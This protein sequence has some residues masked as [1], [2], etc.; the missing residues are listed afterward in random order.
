MAPP[1]TPLQISFVSRHSPLM[2]RSSCESAISGLCL[3]TK[4]ICNGVFGGATKQRLLACVLMP[5]SKGPGKG[6]RPIAMMEVLVK[7]A[8]HYLMS[9]IEGKLP[10]LFPRIQFGVKK[11]G[12]SESAAHLTRALLEQSSRLHSDTIVLK[13]DFQNA[14]NAASRAHIWR[15]MLTQSSTEPVWKMFHW[16]YSDPSQLL[17]YGRE[18]LHSVLESSEGM[19][20]GDPFSACFFAL[21]AAAVRGGHTR[22]A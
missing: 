1:N 17:V 7:L 9:L 20:Q 15:T 6:L 16:A 13:T 14:F 5:I 4:D 12:G 2:A 22:S 18:G 11:A 8:A 19:R 21:G 10:S 3:L